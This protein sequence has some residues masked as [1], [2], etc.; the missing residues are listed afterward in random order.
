MSLSGQFFDLA[1]FICAM[2]LAWYVGSYVYGLFGNWGYV[3]GIV[4]ALLELSIIAFIRGWD[5]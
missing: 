3:A 2:A 4:I 1:I 5:V